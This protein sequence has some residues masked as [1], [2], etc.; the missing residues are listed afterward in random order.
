MGNQESS[1]MLENFYSHAI[2]KHLHTLN[3]PNQSANPGAKLV[4]GG[5]VSGGYS[6]L[7]DYGNSLYSKA[8]EELIRGIAKDVS[9]SLQVNDKF[10]DTAPIAD[11]IAKFKKILPNPKERKN[12]KADKNIHTSICKELAR[13]LNKRYDMNVVDEDAEPHMICQKVSEIMYSLFTG[14]HTEF[15][16]ISGDVQ[17][18]VRNLQVLREY[19]DAA[20]K[21]ILNTM[22]SSGDDVVS[23]EAENIK[24]LYEKL[25]SEIDRQHTILANLTS[26]VIGPL[27]NSLITMLEDNKDF[28]GL[29]ED[30]KKVVGSVQFG[31]KL[32]YLLSG[33]SDIANAAHLVDKALKKI[34]ISVKEYKDIRDL[35]ELRDKVYRNMID[36]KPDSTE[37]HKMLAA[38]DI[39]YR[40]DLA[41]NDIVAYLEKK[42]GG[43]ENRDVYT[44]GDSDLTP[45]F[46]DMAD[47]ATY[48]YSSD[49]PFKG[50]TQSYRKSVSKQIRDKDLYRKQLFV[51]FNGQ[52][53]EKYV[54]IKHSLGLLGKKIGSE[55]ELTPEL[56]LFIKQLSNFAN[57]QPDKQNLH[58]ALSGYK[59]DV[60]SAFVKHQFME[61]LLGLSECLDD[62]LKMSNSSLLKDIKVN[63]DA[64]V[65]DVDDFNDTFTKS[66]SGIEVNITPRKLGGAGEYEASDSTGMDSTGMDSKEMDLDLDNVDEESNSGSAARKD[67]IALVDEESVD[68]DA[69]LKVGGKQ[70]KVLGGIL[71][72]LSDSEFAHFKTMKKAIREIDYYY[73]IAY[74]KSNMNKASGDYEYNTENYENILGE[75]AGYIIDQIQ[76]KYNHLIR[77][78]QE[79]TEQPPLSASDYAKMYAHGRDVGIANVFQR[80][81]NED[82]K[83][84]KAGAN[85]DEKA[86]LDQYVDGYRF[87]LEYIR[88]SN[89]EMI[90]A[91]QALD[92]YLSKFTKNVQMKPDQ[93]KEFAQVLEQIEVVAKWF[94][95]KSGDNL[96]GAFEAFDNKVVD[97]ENKVVGFPNAF[98][99]TANTLIHK[100][101]QVRNTLDASYSFQDHYYKQVV[102]TVSLA[103]G[104]NLAAKSLLTANPGRF[105]LPRMLTK[106]Q[107]VNLVKQIEKSIKSV[108]ALENIIATFS[109][110]NVGVSENVHTFMSSGM[111]FKAFMKY[112][113]ASVIS[114]GY[115]SIAG[116]GNPAAAGDTCI[117]SNQL[118]FPRRYNVLPDIHFNRTVSD[119]ILTA[120]SR[121]NDALTDMKTVVA[122]EKAIR[123]GV[124]LPSAEAKSLAILDIFT[125][126]VTAAMEA[127]AAADRAHQAAILD[128]RADPS[129][130]NKNVTRMTMATLFNINVIIEEIDYQIMTY[131][132]LAGAVGAGAGAART[133]FATAAVN[134]GAV[135]AILNAGVAVDIATTG[136]RIIAVFTM[137]RNALLDAA[138]AA[139][140]SSN[141]FLVGPAVGGAAATFVSGD[142]AALFDAV[143]A[144]DYGHALGAARAAVDEVKDAAAAILVATVATIANANAAVT[145]LRVWLD[146]P[147]IAVPAPLATPAITT[148]INDTA[149]ETINKSRAAVS[150]MAAYAKM[151]I[152]LRFNTDTVRWEEGN[153]GTYLELCNPLKLTNSS[154]MK[155]HDVCDKIFEMSLKSM[156]SKIF[157]VIGTYTLF[158]RP[159]KDQRNSM[160]MPTNPLR[161]ILG[162]AE[163]KEGGDARREI[164]KINP[165]ATELYVRLPLLAEWYRKVFEFDKTT[166]PQVNNALPKQRD[167]L[168]SLIPDNNSVW[169]DLY[170]VIFIDARNIEDG[171]YP[172]E[173]ANRIIEAVNDI[174]MN[175]RAKKKDISA[176]EI[177]SEF[178]VDINKRYGFLMRSEINAYIDEKYKYVADKENYPD[179]E[180][181]DY[182]L[183]DVDDQMGRNPAPSD[184][185]RSFSKGVS[186]KTN[187][188]EDFYRAV[189]RFR[190]SVEANLILAPDMGAANVA[191]WKDASFRTV[192]EISL[193]GVVHEM[194]RK[195]EKAKT[196]ED[197]YR[198][199]HEQLHGVEKFGDIDQQKL[200]LFH[201]TVITPLT[202]LYFTYLILNDYNKFFVSLNVPVDHKD[203]FYGDVKMNMNRAANVRNPN[204]SNHIIDYNNKTF[205]GDNNPYK[206]ALAANL[207]LESLYSVNDAEIYLNPNAAADFIPQYYMNNAG[208][209]DAGNTDA[210]AGD[211][212]QE[213]KQRFMFDNSKVMEEIL[214]KLMNVG[215]DMNGLTDVYFTGSGSKN[216]YPVLNYDKLE[217]TCA[218]L[219]ANAK[220]S[221]HNLRRFVPQSLVKKV[222]DV[223]MTDAAGVTGEN[224]ISLFYL[225][226]HLFDRLFANKYGNGLTD[227]NTGL[228]NLWIVMTKKYSFN[229]IN[230]AGDAVLPR[231][232]NVRA[233][234][235]PAI[236]AG[237][238]SVNT[239]FGEYYY[240]SFNDVFSKLG[241]WDVTMGDNNIS[242]S[243]GFRT[244]VLTQKSLQFPAFFAPIFKSGATLGN[245]RTK[246]ERQ[247]FTDA[248]AVSAKYET[249]TG[250]LGPLNQNTAVL[251]Y[252]DNNGAYA[253]GGVDFKNSYNAIL[254]VHNLYDYNDTYD[255][256]RTYMTVESAANNVD[257]HPAEEN[258]TARAV[259]DNTGALNAADAKESLH[260][261]LGLIPKLNNLLYKYVMLFMDKSNR[262][263]YKPLL[264]KFVNGHNS[265]DVLQGKNINDRPI[266]LENWGDIIGLTG[267]N[268]TGGLDNTGIQAAIPGAVGRTNLNCMRSSV[269]QLEP[270]KGAVLF[271]SLANALKGIMVSQMDRITGNSPMYIEDNL[272]NV[273]EYQKELMRAYLPAFE[274]ELNLLIKK[275]DFLRRCLEETQTRVY[276]WRVH[277]QSSDVLQDEK[278]IVLN[279]GDINYTQPNIIPNNTA[280]AVSNGFRKAYLISM[281]DDI[282]TSAKSLLRCVDE[283]QKELNDVP[284]YFEAYNESITDYNNRNGHLPLM[285]LSHVTHLMN[286][287]IHRS[288]FDDPDFKGGVAPANE[289][290]SEFR[291]ALVPTPDAGVGSSRFKFTYGTRGLLHYGQKPA[292]EFMPGV[293]ALL[294]SYNNKV[295][296]AAAFDKTLLSDLSRDTIMLARWV[297]DYMYHKQVLGAHRWGEMRRLVINNQKTRRNGLDATGPHTGYV[298]N[299][300]CQTGK[301]G[302]PGDLFWQETSNVL[303]LVEGDNFKQSVYRMVSCLYG[304]NSENKLYGLER[305][306]Y[307]IY[308]ILDMNVVPVNV[309]ALQREIPFSN[310]FN[311]SYTFDH[312]IKNFIGVS[313][314]TTPL[315]DIG[316]EIPRGRLAAA[317][318][319]NA[320]TESTDKAYSDADFKATWH[321]EDTLVR[322]LIY[323][324]GFRRLREFV[325]NTYRI[326]AGNTSLSLNKPKYLSDQLWNKTLLNVLYDEKFDEYK[327]PDAR[328]LNEARRLQIAASSAIGPALRYRVIQTATVAANIDNDT[329]EVLTL[330]V[331]QSRASTGAATNILR[332][333]SYLDNRNVYTELKINYDATRG[334]PD[335][336]ALQ[337]LGYEG[338]LRYQSK[339][340]RWVEWT[341]QLQRI[342]RLMMRNQLDWVSD[343]VVQD[344]DA[345]SED[346]TEYRNNNMFNVAE[347]E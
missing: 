269:C 306:K 304:D 41:H 57:S 187:T 117:A 216:N 330:A 89:I 272:A 266:H 30:L 286:F 218:D 280:T 123:I 112:C 147:I 271:A 230:I 155:Y 228:K 54:R 71:N 213:I 98:L 161:Q 268:G 224:R 270:Q 16:T 192:A 39:L 208:N 37:L 24:K 5:A 328:D 168:V 309:H 21:K 113:V 92:L 217:A 180:R 134:A 248:M 121:I 87:I 310:L 198:I 42:R 333:F 77:G 153:P 164:V 25:S 235:A 195:L 170:R 157:T 114:V 181:V 174:W 55:I 232:V 293:S 105:Y 11:V 291:L 221:L 33:T 179:E 262:K 282:S 124:G 7:E 318:P 104:N 201:E 17:R 59:K 299:L 219:F 101:D 141:H 220:Q 23:T 110:V 191:D 88:S 46:A 188:L 94:T 80:S 143:Y 223:N 106:N 111:M 61:N 332:N 326:M 203:P 273:N 200:L 160:S 239:D 64:L 302:V 212:G 31:E 190:Q 108:R 243:L 125:N 86:K 91:A 254:G 51:A 44:G 169:G 171:A 172:G 229:G 345:T 296:G 279:N 294:D 49:S 343:V 211:D 63:I 138:A 242:E 100:F 204:I 84:A 58:I 79:D 193:T 222:E 73:R 202:V 13:S 128:V 122:D 287:N 75:E 260:Q 183:L 40:N 241:F 28:V 126:I 38:A 184:R 215:L 70:Q 103:G 4:A 47:Q 258:F 347:F 319:D 18:I 189:R 56:D 233:A 67:N 151:G 284:L 341:V 256:D 237:N 323:P 301:A 297:T 259:G 292:I 136:Q 82:I 32:S 320:I 186:K 261:R 135:A 264:E 119:N 10:A 52:I 60:N 322:H 334:V 132:G 246:P 139:A 263:I 165:D 197:K 289:T 346:I 109:R 14:L 281:Y 159:A 298:R 76:M 257:F 324:L 231:G 99:P 234:A 307:R 6:A 182:D 251:M 316:G 19:V 244:L 20:N 290:A 140:A 313:I 72:K 249:K 314:K 331:N 8:K 150:F 2:G 127:Q 22:A 158:N 27:G 53:K 146:V 210:I 145:A 144:Y 148:R 340:V 176:R 303:N 85:N 175:F 65:K 66:L 227:A 29:T 267:F 9:K 36:S 69:S 131:A 321:P 285:P 207:L 338:Y 209:T 107:A 133:D 252:S 265:K 305:S 149:L 240:N 34:G 130:E 78:C 199:V 308:N 50:R 329:K 283:V 74:I 12:V 1:Q 206:Q 325:N 97:A 154:I 142:L 178:V 312:M 194:K 300:S 185:F 90:E 336:N 120:T 48:V 317:D 274:K 275:S 129:D 250:G 96:A 288:V 45:S 226:E 335:E 295:G 236:A 245:P 162:G 327:G 93:I 137:L 15:L 177:L 95:D 115:L 62:L 156:I 277:R 253:P 342:L 225:Q 278:K 152:A 68:E 167:P 35:H 344:I 214:R 276:K 173:Y 116:N 339:L 311:Y 255:Q 81:L 83:I 166:G 315:S 238:V 118:N 3:A 337:R 247:Y 163:A 43:Y 102:D 26:S 205:K 196:E